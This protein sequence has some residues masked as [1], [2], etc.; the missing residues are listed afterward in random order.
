MI[1]PRRSTV[2]A[3]PDLPRTT[4]PSA[5]CRTAGPW[6]LLGPQRQEPSRRQA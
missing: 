3:P 2:R 6:T 4:P 5:C 1:G